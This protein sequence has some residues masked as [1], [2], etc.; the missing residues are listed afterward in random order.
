MLPFC[1]FL[2]LFWFCTHDLKP[3]E[4]FKKTMGLTLDEKQK[5]MRFEPRTGCNQCQEDHQANIPK[6]CSWPLTSLIDFHAS[7]RIS[8][9][10]GPLDVLVADL[11]GVVVADLDG[12]RVGLL[13]EADR[14]NLGEGLVANFRLKWEGKYVRPLGHLALTTY[15][16][17]DM[18]LY[19]FKSANI[20]SAQLGP[21]I[22]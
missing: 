7:G 11:S 10:S 16:S 4:Y 20:Q 14:A 19:L 5:L 17:L 6:N 13:Q 1:P 12:H 15:G 3:K 18:I 21:G 9:A 8:L 2:S 22:F